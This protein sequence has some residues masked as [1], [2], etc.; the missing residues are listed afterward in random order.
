MPE[1]SGHYEKESSAE[2]FLW[3]SR[4]EM[5]YP[6]NAMCQTHR[7][8]PNP[9]LPGGYQRFSVQLLVPKAIFIQS[10]KIYSFCEWCIANTRGGIFAEI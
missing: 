10:V 4:P 1:T 9:V 2:S 8:R 5:Q 7:L 3:I 6:L